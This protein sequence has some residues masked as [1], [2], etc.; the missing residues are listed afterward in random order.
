M[1]APLESAAD[2]VTRL[3]GCLNDLVSITALPALS[4]GGEPDQT[5]ST[6]LDT[7]LA[8]LQLAF[9]CVRF[10][11]PEG[12]TFIE[13]VRVAESLERTAR[14]R[15]ISEG[16]DSSLGDAPLKWPPRTQVF[17]GDVDMSVASA[18]LG[19]QSE[20]GVVVAGSQ[21]RD[22]PSERERFLLDV[23]A[24]QA[25]IGLQHAR[26]LSE[27]KRLAS[28]LDERVARRTNELAASNEL[29]KQEVA[30]RR[31]AE[32]TLRDSERESG[33]IVDTIPGLVA[34][35]TPGGEVDVVNNQLVEYCGQPLEAM[36][37]WGTNGTVHSEDLP[38]VIQVFTQAITSGDPYDFEARIRRFDGV[39]RWFQV[40]GLPLHDTIGHIARWYVLLSDIDDRKRAEDAIRERERNLKL[41]IDTIPALAWSAR[42]DGSAEFFNQHFLDFMGLSAE[43]ASDWGWTSVVHLE[44]MNGLATTWQR[45]MASEGPGEAERDCAGMT[46]GIGGSSSARTRCATRRDTSSSGTGYTLTSRTGSGPR[47]SPGGPTTVSPTPSG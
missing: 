32:E 39:Y 4:T 35:L 46:E 34:I 28:D 8:M 29:L 15:E 9:V 13:I 16:L 26:L 36:K 14:A 1:E 5:V 12:G 18:H 43:Q 37:Q 22:F 42:P 6:L 44:D 45:I 20:V 7:L 3:R 19:L 47:R 27:Q 21:R 10:N 25:A 2:E 17:I 31:R 30:E 40:R 24:N 11:D 38:R 41:I 33:L 23:A